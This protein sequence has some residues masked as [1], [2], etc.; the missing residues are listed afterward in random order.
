MKLMENL[1]EIITELKTKEPDLFRFEKK[2]NEELITDVERDLCIF[3]PNS[4]KQFLANFNGGFID[5]FP[6]NMDM[7][8][9]DKIWNSNYIFSLNE[10]AAAYSKR[11]AQNWKFT[12]KGSNEYPFIPFARTSMNEHLIFLNPLNNNES[13]IFEAIHDEPWYEW[14]LKFLDFS[15]FLSTYID[16]G[17]D[18]NFANIGNNVTLEKYLEQYPLTKMLYFS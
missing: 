16:M 1:I 3:L 13:C 17:G 11:S 15:D 6:N 4:Y 7:S 5:L 10:M 8:T 18:I 14:E 9:G 2:L 12:P